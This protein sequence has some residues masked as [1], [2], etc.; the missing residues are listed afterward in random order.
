MPYQR[1]ILK[2]CLVQSIAA[3]KTLKQIL[4]DLPI[5]FRKLPSQTQAILPQICA[6]VKRMNK[7]GITIHT[8]TTKTFPPPGPESQ[9]YAPKGLD[10]AAFK[11]PRKVRS[12][13]G[14]KRATDTKSL[15]FKVGKKADPAR[16]A[17]PTHE[18][19]EVEQAAY[20]GKLPRSM[21]PSKTKPAARV[22]KPKPSPALEENIPDAD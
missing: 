19:A 1:D 13:K 16:L 10:L 2:H 8:T 5:Q 3:R 17:R 15:A 4:A 6:L 7:R 9:P 22:Q 20:H 21:R 11:K 18:A 14:T 12:D